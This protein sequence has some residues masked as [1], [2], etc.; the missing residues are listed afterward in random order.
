[1]YMFAFR[2]LLA[3]I[4][5]ELNFLEAGRGLPASEAACHGRK[6]PAIRAIKGMKRVDFQGQTPQDG[7]S[8]GKKKLSLNIVSGK[9]EHR[10]FGSGTIDLSQLSSVIVDGDSAYLD[11]GALHAKSKVER[12][13]KFSVNK[14]D[15]PNGRPCWVVWVAVGRD[16]AGEKYYAGVTSCE[17]LI[18]EEAKRGWKI[19]ADH[20]N[21]MDYALKRRIILDNL[22]AAQR[23]ALRKLLEERDPDMWRRS[24]DELKSALA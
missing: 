10:G 15:V 24:S 19:L 14:D 4:I 5:R 18:D 12:G 1:M 2:G 11:M 8:V 23:A 21:R 9:N 7:P 13:I 3:K 20:V 22:G 16:E 17:M 6:R